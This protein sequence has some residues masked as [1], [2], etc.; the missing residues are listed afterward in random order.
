MQSAA[1]K[2]W[3]IKKKKKICQP[4]SSHRFIHSALVHCGR[5]VGV[6][7]RLWEQTFPLNQGS[8]AENAGFILRLANSQKRYN[9][10][11]QYQFLSHIYEPLPLHTQ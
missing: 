4:S 9:K 8:A 2:L 3:I 5:K 7:V 10:I 1:L 11:Y 6:I